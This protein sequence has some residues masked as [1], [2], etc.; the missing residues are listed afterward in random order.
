MPCAV[1]I[2]SVGHT[3]EEAEGIVAGAEAAGADFIELVSYTG[4]IYRS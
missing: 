3:L 1:V 4:F 2:A